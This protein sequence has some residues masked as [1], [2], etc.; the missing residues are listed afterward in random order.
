L[1]L[2]LIPVGVLSRIGYLSEQPDL[3]GWMRV[4]EFMRYT[5]AFYPRWDTAYAEQLREQF[6]LGITLII[7]SF[8][9]SFPKSN[10]SESF[11]G[12]IVASCAVI[13][14]L[15]AWIYIDRQRSGGAAGRGWIRLISEELADRLPRWNR[16]F[17]SPAGAQL[18]FEWRRNGLLLPMFIGGLLA[19]VIGPLSWY[20]RNEPGAAL[21]ILATTLAMPIILALPVGKAFS[22]PDLWSSD[23]SLPSFVA[24]RPLATS[25]LVIVKMKVAALS[26]AISW[27]L[28]FAF[29]LIRFPLAESVRWVAPVVI[30]GTFV[31]WRLAASVGS[32]RDSHRST[33]AHRPRAFSFDQKPP[34]MSLL[35]SLMDDL[36][37]PRIE[38]FRRKTK[39]NRT[40]K[41][42]SSH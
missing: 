10:L 20:L 41:H 17:R 38:G 21:R 40:G 8:L 1:I 4:D 26:A 19:F 9:P 37:R 12:S 28:V 15:V 27:L 22:K 6:G 29:L 42:R 7:I 32:R 3:P 2:L 30:G 34:S 16:P 23:L 36:P 11:L 24:V 39:S 33:G 5:L 14:F 25:E 31:T 13:A 35:S 18:W